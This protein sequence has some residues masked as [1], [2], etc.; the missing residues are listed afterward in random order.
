MNTNLTRSRRGNAFAVP[1][2][3]QVCENPRAAALRLWGRALACLLCS[4]V[5]YSCI[6]YTCI[7]Y[8]C[9]FYTCIF[10]SCLLDSCIL[11]MCILYSYLSDRWIFYMCANDSFPLAWYFSAAFCARP[12][13]GLRK[14]LAYGLTAGGM[15]SR[16]FRDGA[17]V[18]QNQ[19][20]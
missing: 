6:F 10:Y 9:T 20:A 18:E 12:Q 17:A 7:S 2:S 5:L 1:V 11:F 4:C 14:R 8:T 16:T 15:I 13:I 3:M 19:N